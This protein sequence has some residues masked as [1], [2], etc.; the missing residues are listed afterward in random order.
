MAMP[1]TAQT[2]KIIWKQGVAQWVRIGNEVRIYD[3]NNRLLARGGVGSPI[4]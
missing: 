2:G 4:F 3:R 1:A